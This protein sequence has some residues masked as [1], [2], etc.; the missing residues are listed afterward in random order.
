MATKVN[1]DGKKPPSAAT[2][3]IGEPKIRPAAP[4]ARPPAKMRRTDRLQLV[5]VPV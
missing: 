3:L 1:K 2:N 4:L 5:V